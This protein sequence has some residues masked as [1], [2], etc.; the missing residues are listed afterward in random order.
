MK[1]NI[2]YTDTFGGEANYCWVKRATVHMPELTHYGYDGGSNYS[3][4]NKIFERELMKRAKAEI[5][6]TNVRGIK[7]DFGGDISFRPHCS[8]TIMFITFADEY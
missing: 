5:G 1:Y 7:E 4:A 8:N 2:E 3:K 6:L